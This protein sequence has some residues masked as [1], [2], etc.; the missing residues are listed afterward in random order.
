MKAAVLTHFFPPEACAAATRVESLADSL[1]DAGND[2]TVIAPFASFPTGR[3]RPE[4][5]FKVFERK[6]DGRRATV[7]LLSLVARVPGARLLH[8]IGS[9]FASTLYVIFTRER[10]DV[11]VTST[12]PITLAMPALAAAWRH[13]AK[14]VV[15]VRDVYPDI[16]IA[17]GEWRRDGLL[18]RCAE[19]I[20]RLLYARADLVIAVT[21]TAI[22]QIASRGIPRSRLTLARNAAQQTPAVNR[23]P[24]NGRP[25]TAIYAG[26][27]GL[28]TDVGLLLDA[29]AAL[30]DEGIWLE[31]AGGGALAS[32]VHERVRT[33]ALTNV[34]LSGVLERRVALEHIAAA[35]VALVPLRA[36]ITE[37]VP[38][39]LY[40]A[41]S[42]GCPV[43]V[44]ASGEAAS[45]GRSLGAMCTRPGDAQ[46]LADAIRTFA[47]LDAKQRHELGERGRAAVQERSGR[48]AIMAELC[49]RICS[50]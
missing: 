50:L 6:R 20:V 48:S 13:R 23:P 44:A 5:R 25:F 16:A 7:R 38:T 32:A 29:A 47:Q 1:N 30:K 45:E 41:L 31:I 22:E 21:P 11:I 8:W 15:D 34:V 24:R 12:P 42:V 27:L 4:D 19:Q 14:L 3:L 36:G 18:A 40:D 37:S 46:A 2:V 35:D 26:N 9:S 49:R 17:M 39:K 43:I 33:Q 10:F 28:A